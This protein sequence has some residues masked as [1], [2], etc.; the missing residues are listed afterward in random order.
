MEEN[1]KTQNYM[2]IEKGKILDSFDMIEMIHFCYSSEI[3]DLG[4]S[5]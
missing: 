4:E 5:F 3:I 2:K 1:Y